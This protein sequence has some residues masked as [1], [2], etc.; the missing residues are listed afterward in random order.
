MAQVSG[1]SY[2]ESSET[3]DAV[4]AK[5]PIL[6]RQ[7]ASAWDLAFN[8]VVDEPHEHHA[9]LP[10]SVLLSVV[11]LSLLWGWTRE[12]ALIALA[13]TGVCS[14][15]EIFVAKRGGLILPE[16]AQLDISRRALTQRTLLCC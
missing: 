9:A 5:R 15:G 6:R 2:G 3:L 12:S 16:D 7:V 4:T 14:I 11:A 1:K 10:H 8:W 13:W